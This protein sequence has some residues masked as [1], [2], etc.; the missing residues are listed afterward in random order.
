M[1]LTRVP[2]RDKPLLQ[3]E[4]P[5]EAK[6]KPVK[7]VKPAVTT[8]TFDHEKGEKKNVSG[9]CYHLRED[10]GFPLFNPRGKL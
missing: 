8:Y 1:S 6:K 5:K 3:A 10:A 9:K 2:V 7:S 4:K